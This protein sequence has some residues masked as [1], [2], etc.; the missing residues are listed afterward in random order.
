[1]RLFLRRNLGICGLLLCVALFTPRRVSAQET[2]QE[3]PP[4]TPAVAPAPVRLN[5]FQALALGRSSNPEW[6]A[7]AI[8]PQAA[9]G[10]VVQA[11]MT[12][13]PVISLRTA[14]ELPFFMESIGLSAS[15]EIELG[16]KRE[17]RIRVAEARLRAA[18]QRGLDTERQLRQQLRTQFAEALYARE[19][20]ALRQE[21]LAL[22]TENL[23]LTRERLKLGDVAGVDVM[24]LETQAARGQAALVEAQGRQRGTAAALAR[25]LGQP[26]TDS[27]EWD[28]QLGSAGPDLS[29]A[30]LQA[31]VEQ[32]A[33]VLALGAEQEAAQ[34]DIDLQRARGVSNLTA[35]LGIT[36]ERLLIDGDAVEP[37]GAI[38]SIRENSWVVGI[39][40]SMPLPINDTNEG[41]IM[42][43]QAVAETAQLQQ[44]VG[45]QRAGAEVAQ[46]YYEWRAARDAAAILEDTAIRRARQVVDITTRAYDLGFRSLLNVLQ[47]RQEYLDLRLQRL[48]ALR[49]QELALTRLE[50]AVGGQWP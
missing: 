45:R 32:R 40:L 31:L 15:Q 2:P 21:T 19:L 28:G 34:R 43:A 3:V 38:E 9:A 26:N 12:P 41:N 1:M 47:A 39:T 8:S 48:E 20:V 7:A 16:G 23:R 49:T 13:N 4:A 5:F 24:Q 10:D 17:A 44:T 6:R 37:A 14:I 35:G 11:G 46:A 25:L 29:L 30:E 36:R 42:R 18:M 22:T 33:D 27:I 50:A